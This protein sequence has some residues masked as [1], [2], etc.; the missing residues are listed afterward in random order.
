MSR[1]KTVLCICIAL[2]CLANL[3][4]TA[5]NAIHEPVMIV[6]G[7]NSIMNETRSSSNASV[8]MGVYNDE[9]Y[10]CPLEGRYQGWLCK[11]DTTGIEKIYKLNTTRIVFGMIDSNLYFIKK[12]DNEDII[13]CYDFIENKTYEIYSDEVN[14][15]LPVQITGQSIYIPLGYDQHLRNDPPKY[16][17]IKDKSVIGI[18]T[19]INGE[20]IADMVFYRRIESSTTII[21]NRKR[22]VIPTEYGTVIHRQGIEN[23]LSLIDTDDKIVS[24]FSVPGLQADSAVTIVDDVVYL[25]FLR[26][27]K[28]GDIGMKRFENDTMEGTYRISLKDYSV[29]KLNDN[30]YD[31]LYYFGDAYIYACDRDGSIYRLNLDGSVKDIL[32][33]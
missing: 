9:L 11:F 5:D 4:C 23:M 8:W 26:Y 18:T 13:T 22:S 31:G 20:P 14:V 2:V 6:N 32:Y 3:S 10:F 30:I 7:D 27:E 25:S 21:P 28:E 12:G 17:Q 24:L 16:I 1:I 29:E 19:E 15:F 33:Q